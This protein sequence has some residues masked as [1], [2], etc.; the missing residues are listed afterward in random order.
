MSPLLE[1]YNENNYIIVA[2]DH[3]FKWVEAH[4]MLTTQ[5]FA[6]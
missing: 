3:Y 1:T 6:K 5:P 4:V 2:I